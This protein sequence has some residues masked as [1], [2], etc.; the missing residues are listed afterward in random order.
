MKLFTTYIY[1]EVILTREKTRRLCVCVCD[2][3]L[4]VWLDQTGPMCVRI[5]TRLI[6]QNKFCFRFCSALSGDHG[7]W[8]SCTSHWV[9]APCW[10]AIVYSILSAFIHV[11]G[12]DEHV[13]SARLQKPKQIRSYSDPKR[14]SWTFFYH[15]D[16]VLSLLSLR[17]R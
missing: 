2:F 6:S 15:R 9:I 16:A 5:H 11:S 1:S 10:Q 12:I 4:V 14:R 3:V 7:N 17:S 13:L 8:L